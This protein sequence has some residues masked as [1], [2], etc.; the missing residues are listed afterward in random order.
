MTMMIDPPGR[1]FSCRHS[2]LQCEPKYRVL[3]AICNV[4]RLPVLR[5]APLRKRIVVHWHFVRTHSSWS[6]A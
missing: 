5:H 6:R 2:V 4:A 1:R 3:R